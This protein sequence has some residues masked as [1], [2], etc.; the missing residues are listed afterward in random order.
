MEYTGSKKAISNMRNEESDV[1]V[2][3]V[4][5]TDEPMPTT[6]MQVLWQKLTNVA[7]VETNGVQPVPVEERNDCRVLNVFTV[8]FTLSTNLLPWVTF[9]S[10]H[11]DLH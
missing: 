9:L 7:A 1:E 4:E 11:R 10:L 3:N 6:R 2:G 8:W 5:T